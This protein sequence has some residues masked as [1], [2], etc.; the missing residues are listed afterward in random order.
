MMSRIS[1]QQ[2]FMGMTEWAAMRSTCFRGNTGAL[3]VH[4]NDIVSMGY[5]GPPS[6]DDHCRGNEC[7]LT[8]GG[9][10]QRSL[11]A[12]HNALRRATEKLITLE[13]PILISECDLYTLSGPCPVCA[14]SIYKHG[15]KRVFYRHPYRTSEGVHR[16]VEWGVK[17]YRVLP[18]GM[19]VAET[20][21]LIV[22]PEN[23]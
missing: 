22:D 14:M 11:H 8:S 1:R 9:G 15:I 13:S 4:N 17:V 10:C 20:T 5:N 7:E 2:M 6:G 21:H 18:A 19:I 16:L 12:E 3:V 23:L